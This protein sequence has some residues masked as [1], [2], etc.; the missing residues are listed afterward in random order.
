MNIEANRAV[1]ATKQRHTNCKRFQAAQQER[2][3]TGMSVWDD[4]KMSLNRLLDQQPG[5]L[6]QFPNPEGDHGRQPPFTISLAA[7]AVPTAEELHRN[8][9]DSRSAA[10]S[11]TRYRGPTLRG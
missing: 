5:T 10:M 7:W 9:G 4:F 8:F 1:S 2:I 3:V 6:M 11:R